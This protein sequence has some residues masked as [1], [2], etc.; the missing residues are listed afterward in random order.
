M[1]V[2]TIFIVLVGEELAMVKILNRQISSPQRVT[3][4]KGTKSR[5]GGAHQHMINQ[6]TALWPSGSKTIIG[7]ARGPLHSEALAF[8]AP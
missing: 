6:N 5:A 4:R 7:P 1:H 8:R 2:D 3:K